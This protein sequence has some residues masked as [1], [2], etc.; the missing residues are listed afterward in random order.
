MKRLPKEGIFF[1][2]NIKES[3]GCIVGTC[4]GTGEM[5]IWAGLYVM[6]VIISLCFIMLLLQFIFCCMLDTDSLTGSMLAMMTPL[7]ECSL[8]S[9]DLQHCPVGCNAKWLVFSQH[10]LVILH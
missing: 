7:I 2:R 5:G 9:K 8:S 6:T 1:S 10:H 4:P 3:G